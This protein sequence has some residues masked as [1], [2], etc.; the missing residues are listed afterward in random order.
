MTP[1]SRCY[2]FKFPFLSIARNPH[3]QEARFSPTQRAPFI[4]VGPESPLSWRKAVE[5]LAY[6]CQNELGFETGFFSANE[7][8]DARFQ[9]D[10]VLVFYRQEI[11][12][13]QPSPRNPKDFINYYSFFGAVGVRWRDWGHTP[14]TWSLDWAW[15]HPYERRRGHLSEAWPFLLRMFPN[16]HIEHP[17][18]AMKAFLKKVGYQDMVEEA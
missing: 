1:R 16:P 15:V 12:E 2:D 13:R 5:D 4:V 6:Y 7:G 14:A 18:E 17:S 10:R 9:R 11:K 3:Q 8:S